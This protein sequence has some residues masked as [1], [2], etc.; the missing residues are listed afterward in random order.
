M[1][2]ASVNLDT[3]VAR[4]RARLAAPRPRPAAVGSAPTS[5]P[6]P[7]GFRST[8]ARPGR[9]I[10]AEFKRRSPSG[11]VL[12]TDRGP[13]E[14]A[15]IYERAGAAALSVLTEPEFFAGSMADLAE[16]RAACSLPV[17]RK[18]F[19]VA[20]EQIE[21]A[22]AAGADAILLIAAAVDQATLVRLREAARHKGLDVLVEVHDA[23]ELERAL[24]A[25]ADL[26]GVNNRDLRSMEVRIETSLELGPRIPPGV[27]AVAESGIKSATDVQHLA[28]AGFHAF[29]IGETLMRAEDPA[30][31]LAQLLGREGR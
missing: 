30:T 2:T 20:E 22:S 19:I 24:H 28:E 18:D 9:R 25:G 17:L 12:R 15:A 4:V 23:A 13:G 31:A 1:N 27:V 29:L 21:E 14:T 3:I 16:A 26:V 8:L 10:I 11:G 7:R 6:A 5:R